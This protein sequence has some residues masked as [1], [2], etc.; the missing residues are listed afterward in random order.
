MSRGISEAQG[1]EL[2]SRGPLASLHHSHVGIINSSQLVVVARSHQT[3]RRVVANKM[4]HVA[5]WRVSGARPPSPAVGKAA[6]EAVGDLA[7]RLRFVEDLTNGR[8]HTK[9]YRHS[10]LA[11]ERST[12]RKQQQPSTA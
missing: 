10:P 3:E 6:E 11:S 1:S 4:F 5:V 9:R 12:K 7:A 8:K 2:I